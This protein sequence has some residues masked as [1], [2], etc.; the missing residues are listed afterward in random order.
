MVEGIPYGNI[1]LLVGGGH[2]RRS[3]V[4]LVVPSVALGLYV[5]M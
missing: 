5:S 2:R 4:S 3:V 1:D